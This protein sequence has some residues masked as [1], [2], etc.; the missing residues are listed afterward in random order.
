MSE[1]TGDVLADIDPLLWWLLAFTGVCIVAC[2]LTLWLSGL[3][4]LWGAVAT[5]AGCVLLCVAVTWPLQL[6]IA[7][8]R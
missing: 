4:P 2:V 7:R 8:R 3:Q 5:T 6:W 1:Q